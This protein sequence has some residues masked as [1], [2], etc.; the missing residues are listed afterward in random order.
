MA[1]VSDQSRMRAKFKKNLRRIL[2]ALIGSEVDGESWEKRPAETASELLPHASALGPVRSTGMRQLK[3]VRLPLSGSALLAIAMLATPAATLAETTSVKFAA[4]GDYG[5][6]SGSAA[7]AQLIDNQGADFIITAGDNCYDAR[8][9]ATQVGKHYGSWVSGSRFW[10]SL[11]NHDY[12]DPCGGGSAASGYRAYFSLPGNERYY[13]VR[14][15]S[16]ELFAVNSN[17]ADPNGATQTSA[18]GL[19]LRSAL[20][21]STAPWKIVYFHHSPFSSGAE[22]GSVLRMRWPFEAW[23]VDAVIS[24]HDHH[25]ERVIRDDN[26]N[27]VKMPYLISGLGGQSIRAANRADPGGSVVKYSG[28]YGAL[29]ATATDTTLRFE[30]RNTSGAII[31]SYS[32]TKTGGTIDPPT[33]PTSRPKPHKKPKKDHP[34]SGPVTKSPLEF[35]TPPSN[36]MIRLRI[37]YYI[38]PLLDDRVVSRR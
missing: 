34:S 9:I 18:Q 7:V 27:G 29:F 22:H 38:A 24:G 11:G 8:P 17:L 5:D 35:R 14:K 6:G 13:Q 23:G 32:M 28:G 10:P 26:D 33:D 19:W 25:Y 37:D 16:V 30:F 36:F 2:N 15:G 12:S 20:A 3:H 4:F 21:A 31:D 1:K